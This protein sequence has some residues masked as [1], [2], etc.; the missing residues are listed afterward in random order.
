[1]SKYKILIVEDEGNIFDMITEELG[2]TEY[3]FVRARN[4]SQAKG[5]YKYKSPFDCYVV[6]LQINSLGLEEHEMADFSI[7]QGYAWLKNY[8]FNSMT[9]EE[10]WN[11]KEKTIICSKYVPQFKDRFSE[12]EIAGFKIVHK[13]FDFE[14]KV[15]NFV[16]QICKK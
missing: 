13:E 10:I 6:D 7:F 2:E 8:V 4:V 14:K 3:E 1:M 15:K 16:S 11:F 12:E 5:A 9:Q